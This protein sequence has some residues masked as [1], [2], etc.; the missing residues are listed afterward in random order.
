MMTIYATLR[1]QLPKIFTED[2]SVK[3]TSFFIN[4]NDIDYIIK[5]FLI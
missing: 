4:K 1:Y 2:K 3:N 5:L